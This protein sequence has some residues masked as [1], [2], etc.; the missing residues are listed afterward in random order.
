MVKSAVKLNRIF[1]SV[2][3][4]TDAVCVVGA[5]KNPNKEMRVDDKGTWVTCLFDN[6]AEAGTH[7]QTLDEAVELE[8]LEA[9]PM[10]LNTVNGG[11]KRIF[12]IK[13]IKLGETPTRISSMP[14]VVPRWSKSGSR[15]DT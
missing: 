4:M 3:G 12:E 11:I 7:T 2:R 13:K 10:T 8:K 15:K 5:S 6:G 9:R 14:L 1:P